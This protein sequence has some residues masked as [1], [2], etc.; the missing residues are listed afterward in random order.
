MP[1]LC[2]RRLTCRSGLIVP[3]PV[4]DCVM[5]GA[6]KAMM[7]VRIVWME[8]VDRF[9]LCRRRKALVLLGDV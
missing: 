4:L 3:C 5:C 9:A 6:C 1:V 8:M 7:A 2:D